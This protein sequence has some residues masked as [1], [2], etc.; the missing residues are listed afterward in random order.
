[1]RFVSRNSQRINLLSVGDA[2]CKQGILD[3]VVLLHVSGVVSQDT[4]QHLG[5]LGVS[6]VSHDF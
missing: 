2:C 1:M 4:C 5:V 3:T 6:R